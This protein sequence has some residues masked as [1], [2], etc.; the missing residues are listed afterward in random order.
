MKD[1]VPLYPGRV[2]LVPVAGQENTYDMVRADEPRVEGTPINKASLLKDATAALFGLGTD[3]VPDEVLAKIKEL[4]DGLLTT[5]NSKARIQTGSY[6]GTGTYGASNP[7][8]LT[9]DFVPQA[10]IVYGAVPVKY[11]YDATSFTFASKNVTTTR[12]FIGTSSGEIKAEDLYF[13]FL[14]KKVTFYV[15]FVGDDAAKYQCNKSGVKY[16]YICFG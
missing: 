15:N 7:C 9:F 10:I 16:G 2:K 14:E 1:R 11:D 3:A 12:A 8:S 4:L 5:A 6:T 13:N